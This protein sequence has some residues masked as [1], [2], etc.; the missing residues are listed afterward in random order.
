MGQIF[1][2][3]FPNFCPKF[4]GTKLSEIFFLFSK[5]FVRSL[6]SLL[7]AR[8]CDFSHRGYGNGFFLDWL[9]KLHDNSFQTPYSG[10]VEDFL[11]VRAHH[12]VTMKVTCSLKL[13]N[14]CRYDN[15]KE[16]MHE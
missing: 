5:N 15:E 9:V 16:S 13:R 14:S 10:S 12:A 1:F 8:F 11:E 6:I 2:A 7:K 3:D 4:F